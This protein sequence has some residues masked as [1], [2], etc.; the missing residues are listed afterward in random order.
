M[1]GQTPFPQLPQLQGLW[2]RYPWLEPLGMQLQKYSELTLPFCRYWEAASKSKPSI[3]NGP[4][5][6]TFK[7]GLRCDPT[8][9]WAYRLVMQVSLH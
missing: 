9:G 5:Y 7:Q 3:V 6:M 4:Q 2:R 8:M 1:I